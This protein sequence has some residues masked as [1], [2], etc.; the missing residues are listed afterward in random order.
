MNKEGWE[1]IQ[2]EEVPFADW[3]R[4]QEKNEK[5]KIRYVAFKSK[6]KKRKVKGEERRNS[7]MIYLN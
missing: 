6:Q 2:F 5:R 1:I 4:I 7:N 3:F